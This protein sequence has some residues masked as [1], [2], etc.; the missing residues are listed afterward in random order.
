MAYVIDDDRWQPSFLP[1][2]I[3]EYI[4]Q[5]SPVQVIDAFVDGLNFSS[6]GFARAMPSSTGRPGYDPTDPLKLYGY[7]YLNEVRSSRRIERE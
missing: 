3:D 2:L 5:T 7:G 6:L 1:S 4:D